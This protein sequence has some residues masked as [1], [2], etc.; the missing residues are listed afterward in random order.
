MDGTRVPETRAE[1]AAKL[2]S[3]DVE[4]S[5]VYP[6]VVD[7]NDEPDATL[8][9]SGMELITRLLESAVDEATIVPDAMLLVDEDAG[10]N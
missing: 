3:I 6:T 4:I 8:L 9:Y 1:L 5:E 7:G 10:V 2:D